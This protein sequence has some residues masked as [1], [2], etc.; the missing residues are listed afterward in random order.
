MVTPK[1]VWFVIKD[2]DTGCNKR[3]E[4]AGVLPRKFVGFGHIRITITLR[5]VRLLENV[6][7]VWST[8]RIPEVAGWGTRWAQCAR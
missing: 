1:L 6:I 7:G 3:P 2:H 4:F 5:R 8:P